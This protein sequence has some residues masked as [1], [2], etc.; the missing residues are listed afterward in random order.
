MIRY[1]M[2]K[3]LEVKDALSEERRRLPTERVL[4]GYPYGSKLKC[5]ELVRLFSAQ[6]LL[7]DTEQIL[8]YEVRRSAVQYH[9]RKMRYGTKSAALYSGK[10]TGFFTEH[11]TRIGKVKRV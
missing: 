11:A 1:S 4:Y 2:G 6:S 10:V 8:Q 9:T 7:F 3:Q 5:R